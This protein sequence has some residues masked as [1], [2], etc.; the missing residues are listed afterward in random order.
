MKIL[1]R[2]NEHI[3]NVFPIKCKCHY[4]KDGYNLRYGD[5][6]D[7]CGSELEIDASDIVK[8]PYSRYPNISGDDYGYICPVC[9]HFIPIDIKNIPVEVMYNAPEI[10]VVNG[11]FRCFVHRKKSDIKYPDLKSETYDKDSEK[12]N[13]AQN[14]QQKVK[15]S[16]DSLISEGALAGLTLETIGYII[17]ST[18]ITESL[19]YH[20][21]HGIDKTKDNDK[22]NATDGL[23]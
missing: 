20:I 21:E 9:K 15:L 6:K 2:K 23:Q 7:Y 12:Y 16:M 4:Q 11:I 22:N 19:A 14:Y 5:A 10:S 3:S 18:Y 1:E 8:H 13:A 17:N